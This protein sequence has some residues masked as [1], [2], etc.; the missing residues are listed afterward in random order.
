MSSRRE[1]SNLADILV[2]NQFVDGGLRRA[3]EHF[4]KRCCVFHQLFGGFIW[5]EI[6]SWCK[7]LI[8]STMLLQVLLSLLFK[9]V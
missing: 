2:I 5:S 9:Y 4:F 6:V 1:I 7:L 8:I 3:K